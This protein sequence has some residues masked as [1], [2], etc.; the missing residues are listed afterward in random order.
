MVSQKRS[1]FLEHKFS[2]V[3]TR[4]EVNTPLSKSLVRG[5]GIL[6]SA[7]LGNVGELHRDRIGEK[8]SNIGKP[9]TFTDARKGPRFTH[10]TIVHNKRL[11]IVN[12]THMIIINKVCQYD[13]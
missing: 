8:S 7:L 10:T 4:A 9:I 6:T 5:R 2:T 11:G 3:D 13:P 1:Q 12:T